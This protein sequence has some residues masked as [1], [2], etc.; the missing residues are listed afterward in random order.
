MAFCLGFFRPK[1]YLSTG[2]TKLMN[3]PELE[4]IILHEKYHLLKRDNIFLT[5]VNFIKQL[6]LPFPILAD[7]LDN[8]IKTK[9]NVLVGGRK[10]KLMRTIQHDLI[11][12]FFLRF[13]FILDGGVRHR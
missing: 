7:L 12:K 9:E 13:K 2:L 3:G 11:S 1:I 4:A 8:L 6:F 5:A 10:L